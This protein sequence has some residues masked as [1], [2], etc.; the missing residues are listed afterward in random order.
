MS[1]TTGA[2]HP[3]HWAASNGCEDV[4]EVLIGYGAEV[5]AKDNKDPT[6]LDDAAADGHTNVAQFLRQHGGH[7]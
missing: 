5:N 3:L 2:E 1:R 7:K 4:V 6:P